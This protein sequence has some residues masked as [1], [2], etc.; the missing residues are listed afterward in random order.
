MEKVNIGQQIVL[1]QDIT[2]HGESP[3][4]PTIFKKGTSLFV[5]ADKKFYY[6]LNS[7]MLLIDTNEIEVTN[8][9]SVT[10]I[11]EWI[12]QRISA[13]WGIDEML[14]EAADDEDTS[15]SEQATAFKSNIASALE[16]LGFYDH[17]GNTL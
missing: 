7:K 16:E 14:E 11:A 6:L 3:E 2:V 13:V 4:T 1:N 15:W 10:G 8:G 9:F 5:G 12:Y 17:T